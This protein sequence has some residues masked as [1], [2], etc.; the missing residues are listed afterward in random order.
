MEI[1]PANPSLSW[2]LTFK[3]L[4]VPVSSEPFKSP[5]VATTSCKIPSQSKIYTDEAHASAR[6]QND[7]PHITMIDLSY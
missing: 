7:E 2:P 5:V 6:V 4:L 1:Q 3:T